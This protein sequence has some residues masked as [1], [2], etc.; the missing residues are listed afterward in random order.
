[1]VTFKEH[2]EH[3]EELRIMK[4]PVALFAVMAKL[5]SDVKGAK[6]EDTARMNRK[7]ANMIWVGAQMQFSFLGSL[8]KQIK[9]MDKKLDSLNREIKRLK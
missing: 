9:E 6:D 5:N 3:L 4:N 2:T 7:I 1:M 8:E